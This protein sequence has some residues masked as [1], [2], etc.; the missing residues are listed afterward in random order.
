MKKL[1]IVMILLLS[2]SCG[3]METQ[4]K[5]ECSEGDLC[6][7][8]TMFKEN[9]KDYDDKE[10]TFIY[11]DTLFDRDNWYGWCR[12]DFN[13]KRVYINTIHL[14]SLNEVQRLF[15]IYHEL[16][17]CILHK[18]HNMDLKADGCPASIMNTNILDSGNCL[19]NH[20]IDYSEELKENDKI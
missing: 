11:T 8:I 16:G 12:G 4:E 13:P 7:Y 18:D 3:G 20:F 19:Y 1:I 2:L 6:P 10:I 17:H 15:L 9:I 5:Q 14:P